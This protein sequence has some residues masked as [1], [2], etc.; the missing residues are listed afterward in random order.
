[1]VKTTAGR[2]RIDKRQ[3]ILAAAFVVFARRGYD[4]ACMQEIADEA[5]VAKPTVYNHL[6]DKENLFRHAVLAAADAVLAENLAVV[7]RL[8]TPGTD[9]RATLADVAYRLARVCAGERCRALRS[10][11]YGQAAQFP[12]LIDDVRTRT[13]DRLTDALA[14][15]LARL[16]LA[17]LFR[18]GDPALAAE[19]FL[20]LLTGPLEARSR[21]GTHAVSAANTRIVANAAVDT[22]LRAYRPE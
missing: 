11:T 9:L 1:M 8:R 17:G 20:A 16:S 12:E 10:L 5:G 22:F 19:Q 13:S 7:E 2:G 15:R 6:T 3:A 21:A 18:Q 14:D 4:Q